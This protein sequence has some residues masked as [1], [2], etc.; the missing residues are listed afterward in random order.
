M[1][2]SDRLIAL[3]EG[4]RPIEDLPLN[5]DVHRMR[6]TV[7]RNDADTLLRVVDVYGVPTTWARSGQFGAS[8]YTARNSS[9]LEPQTTLDWVL[10][11]GVLTMTVPAALTHLDAG[12]DPWSNPVPA[13]WRPVTPEPTRQRVA[14]IRDDDEPDEAA[15]REYGPGRWER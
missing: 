3:A 7:Q 10:D 13:D 11:W 15:E 9:I 14:L 6:A 2:L 1:S 4:I 8:R 12:A 5:V